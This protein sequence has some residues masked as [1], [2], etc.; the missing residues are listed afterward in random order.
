MKKTHSNHHCTMDIRGIKISRE[1]T[2]FNWVSDSKD[3][4]PGMTFVHR[5]AENRINI[6]FMGTGRNKK[7]AFSFCCV[8][9]EYFSEIQKLAEQ[10]SEMLKNAQILPS[11]G[12][13]TLYPHQSS[14]KLL[15][16]VLK[17]LGKNKL[18][19]YAIGSSISAL[20]FSTEYRFLG[21]VINDLKQVLRLPANHTP[22][23]PEFKIKQL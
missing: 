3:S 9:T 22:F 12:T 15:G 23:Q 6:V 18:P 5:M 8:E 11:V 21:K 7:S 10:D 2:Q 16:L 4:A 1:L 13:L 20:T 19:V 14:F 17:E